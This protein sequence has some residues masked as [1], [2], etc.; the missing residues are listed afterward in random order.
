MQMN[1]LHYILNVEI[2]YKTTKLIN[3]VHAMVSDACTTLKHNLG[4]QKIVLL[5]PVVGFWGAVQ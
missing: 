1:G 3:Y 5:L 4:V 2:T